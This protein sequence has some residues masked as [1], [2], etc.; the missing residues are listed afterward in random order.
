MKLKHKNLLKMSFKEIKKNGKQLAVLNYEKIYKVENLKKNNKKE[1]AFIGRSNVGKSSLIN[2]ILN[3]KISSTSKNPGRTRG[4]GFIE[5]QSINLIDLPGYGYSKVSKGRQQFWSELIDEYIKSKRLNKIFILIDSR[6]GIQQEDQ[7]AADYFQCDF[8][9]LFTKCDKIEN[10]N[11]QHE[12][13]VSIKTG[14]NIENLRKKIIN[15]I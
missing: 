14:K 10:Q 8:E 5:L 9:F 7:E 13:Y 1:I 11:L 12:S 15:L 2:T 6:K 3:H 4:I